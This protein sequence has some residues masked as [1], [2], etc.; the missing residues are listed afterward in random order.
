MDLDKDLSLKLLEKMLLARKFEE[1]VYDLKKW[2]K[3]DPIKRCID[4]LKT[5]NIENSKIK[6]VKEKVDKITTKAEKLANKIL[7][8][9]GG[10]CIKKY[11]LYNRIIKSLKKKI[12][13]ILIIR[14][15]FND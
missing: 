9:Y 14:S 4:K 10:G 11:A 12:K 7:L 1:K 5:N 15:I 8:R 13:Y 2:K 3:L 6:D